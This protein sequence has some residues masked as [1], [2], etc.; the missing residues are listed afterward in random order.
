MTERYKRSAM[1]GFAILM[2]CLVMG[3]TAGFADTDG[4]V[5]KFADF[6]QSIKF[7]GDMRLRYD[8]QY[9]R[10]DA[11][12]KADRERWRERLRVGAVI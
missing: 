11:P 1:N 6:I 5:L 9:Y 3:A 7:N 10:D 4:S 2:T 8:A 12:T